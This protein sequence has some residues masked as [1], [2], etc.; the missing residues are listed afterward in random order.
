MTVRATKF[1]P[2][3]LLRAPRRSAGLPSPDG[4]LVLFT[5]S[6]YSFETHKTTSEI[7]V[8]DVETGT[9]VQCTGAER[10]KEP[11]WIGVGTEVAWLRSGENGSTKLMV[12]DAGDLSR[13]PYA[14]GTVDA[15]ISNLKVRPLNDETIAIVVVGQA[16]VDGELY[17]PETAS[18]SHSTGR[19]FS[20]L[21]VRHWDTY[22]TSNRNSLFYGTLKKSEPHITESFGRYSLSRLTNAL[23]GTG[24]Q[25]PIPPFGGTDNYDISDNG[26]VLVAKDPALNPATTTK[27]DFYFIP[28]SSFTE[29]SPPKPQRFSLDYSKGASSSPTFSPDGK[30]AVFL[31]M[32]HNGYESDRNRIVLIENLTNPSSAVEILVSSTNKGQWNLS[33]S[34]VLWGNDNH[35]YL[36]CEDAGRVSLFRI[37]AK[38]PKQD[39]WFPEQVET[40]QGSVFDVRP[41]AAG[42][43]QLLISSTS[44]VDSSTYSITDPEHL[45]KLEKVISSLS[46]NGSVFGL[47]Y[48]KQVEHIY[49]KG[50]GDYTVH[51]LVVK[52]STFSKDKKYPLAYLIHGGPQG[53]WDNSWS[54]RWN[55]AVFAEQGYVV[56]CPNPTGS[57][58]FGQEFVDAIK[59]Q[60]GGRPFDDLIKGFEHIEANMPYVDTSRA[61]AL[62]ASY[63][64]FMVNYIQ[65]QPFGRKFKALVTHDGVFSITNQIATDELYFPEHDFGGTLWEHRDEWE[66]WSPSRYAGNWATPH[67]IIHNELDYRLPISEGLAAFNV[68][69]RKGIESK[70]L[71]F[72]DENHWV[73]KPENSLHWHTVVLNWIN[74]YVGLPEYQP[75]SSLVT[76]V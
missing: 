36:Q 66:R 44:L 34:S 46:K 67:L 71:S 49:F 25:S 33:P 31:Q 50:A 53:A 76:Q 63:G 42:S 61:V 41:A 40:P 29:R 75:S 37:P 6:T 12:G 3:V 58:G 54:T 28:L 8:L 56:V 72:P 55:P 9:S 30:K 32:Q 4:K 68:L 19:E 73:L 57:T 62:G 10:D 13:P 64:G 59:G 35:L 1:T 52:P 47:S 17:N 16:T 27:S 18:K 23:R 20:E 15:P 74:K 26:I 39:Y 48:K 70:F 60:W 7:N 2:E 69:Q 24:L 22:L 65:G 14:L 21:F 11:N 43:S 38:P 45:D 5:L 51:A